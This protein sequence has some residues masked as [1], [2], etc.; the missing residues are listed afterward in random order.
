MEGCG[1]KGG[2][3][4]VVVVVVEAFAGGLGWA[5]DKCRDKRRRTR[6]K[7]GEVVWEW[8]AIT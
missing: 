6:P 2:M 1:E 8:L 3:L 4:L 7:L 5:E